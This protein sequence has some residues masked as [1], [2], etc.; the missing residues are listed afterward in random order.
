MSRELI[1]HNEDLL[2]LH[3]LG[4]ELEVRCGHLLLKHVPHVTSDGTVEYGVLVAKL[5]LAGDKTVKPKQHQVWFIGKQP[6]DKNGREIPQIKLN[7][8][9]KELCEGLIVDR[10]FSNKPP[11][12]YENFFHKMMTYLNII[13][14]PAEAVDPRVT[15]RTY[16]DCENDEESVFQY[17]DTA[18]SRAEIGSISTR[19]AGHKIAIVGL[20]GTGSYILDLVAKTPVSEIHLYDGDRFLQHNAFR[21]PGAPSLRVLRRVPFKVDHFKRLYSKMH[22]GI[23]AH[24][25]FLDAGSAEELAS[26]DFVFLCLDSGAARKELID[27]LNKLNKTFI[28]VGMGIE[29]VAGKRTL[30]GTLRVS[31]STPDDRSGEGRIPQR[32]PIDDPDG[33]YVNNI[34][35]ADLNCLNATLA[36]LKWKKL[37]GFYQD[38]EHE[39]FSAYSINT[40]QLASEE[41]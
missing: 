2:K 7:D 33:I 28:D 18:S 41:S 13:S 19:L 36:V 22:K 31:T 34:Q 39:T 27:V 17:A 24:R 29:A 8:E 5:D 1:S 15:A 10:Q 6:C 38:L 3:K 35:V 4:L 20:G 9:R 37:C 40:N 16:A 11:N 12:G 25:K 21:S 14:G 30:I 26:V 32:D 23:R